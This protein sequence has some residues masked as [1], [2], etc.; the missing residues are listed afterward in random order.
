ML[1]YQTWQWFPD[2]EIGFGHANACVYQSQSAFLG[3]G[4][5]VDFQLFTTVQLGRVSQ[6]LIAYL[7][8]GLKTQIIICTIPL[9]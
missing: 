4:D 9:S 6:A 8:Q 7:V 2:Y 5:D 1:L 3:I